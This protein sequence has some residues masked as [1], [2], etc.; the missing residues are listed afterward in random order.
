MKAMVRTSRA[1]GPP[2]FRSPVTFVQV[3]PALVECH[4][5]LL[6]SSETTQTERQSE[7]SRSSITGVPIVLTSQPVLVRLE[8]AAVRRK[9]P[10]VVPT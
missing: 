3:E 1:P 5:G 2:G 4:T 9:R 10:S 7:G 8:P 6:L